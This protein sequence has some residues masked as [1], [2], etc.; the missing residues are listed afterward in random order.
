MRHSGDDAPVV[1]FAL[2]SII[3]LFGT[4]VETDFHAKFLTLSDEMDF[5]IRFVTFFEPFTVNKNRANRGMITGGVETVH[6]SYAFIIRD[7]HKSLANFMAFVNFFCLLDCQCQPL[8]L[9]LNAK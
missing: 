9:S 7:G 8:S 6:R 1:F 3:L 5:P 2:F 4:S